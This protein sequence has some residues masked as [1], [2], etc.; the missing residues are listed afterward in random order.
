[1]SRR[2]GVP[3]AALMCLGTLGSSV[4]AQA[5]DPSPEVA[6][7]GLRIELLA[8]GLAAAAGA[9]MGHVALQIP[10]RECM[11]AH[12]GFDSRLL[13]EQEHVIGPVMTLGSSH[14]HGRPARCGE[15]APHPEVRA[16]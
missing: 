12:G 8:G 1:M 3:V 16:A 4:R 14:P 10:K 5:A 11:I 13:E 15:V 9:L 2:T 6:R 7:G